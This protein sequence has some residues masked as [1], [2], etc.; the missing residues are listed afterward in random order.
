MALFHYTQGDI[1]RHAN[2]VAREHL[3]AAEREAGEAAAAPKPAPSPAPKPAQKPITLA[4]AAALGIPP[5]D[6]FLVSIEMRE[7]LAAGAAPQ[8]TQKKPVSAPAHAGQATPEQIRRFDDKIRQVLSSL[9]TASRRD[10][11]RAVHADR[12]PEAFKVAWRALRRAGS[13]VETD[14]VGRAR[15]WRLGGGE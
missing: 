9:H 15:M 7:K 11:A 4:D 3:E 14:I 13:I 1:D 12:H 6:L 5:G 10:I 2:R 8:G